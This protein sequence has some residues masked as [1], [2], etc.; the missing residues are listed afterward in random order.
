MKLTHFQHTLSFTVAVGSG[1]P[2][3]LTLLVSTRVYFFC[4]LTSSRLPVS[5]V[6]CD[7][8]SSRCKHVQFYH[9]DM[10]S[11]MGPRFLCGFVE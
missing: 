3:V 8:G 2:L 7:L 5:K 11:N 6:S 10:T 4:H 9:R 1:T